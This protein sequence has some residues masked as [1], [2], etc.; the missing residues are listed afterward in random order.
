MAVHQRLGQS[1]RRLAFSGIEETDMDLIDGYIRMLR[2]FLPRAQRDDIARE[3]AEEI[4]AQALDKQ[5]ELGR[6]LSVDEQ[7][8]ILG[9]YGHPL[10]TAARYRSQQHLI[11]PIV[12]PYYWLA[13]KVVL[14]MVLAGHA[15]A[16]L[17]LF[18]GGPSWSEVGDALK[19][20]L[21]NVFAVIAWFTI[22]AALT[23]R[24][25]AK[26]QV[27][28]KWDPRTL[29]VPAELAGRA[30]L[31]ATRA[32]NR[33][34][35]PMWTR[36]ITALEGSPPSIFGLVVGVALSVWWLLA[37]RYPVLMFGP[38]AA[39]LDWGPDM[40]RLYPVLV[41]AQI[42]ALAEHFARVLRPNGRRFLW[43]TQSLWPITGA[44]FFYFVATARHQWVV[45]EGTTTA[46]PW[47]RMIEIAGRSLSLIDLV[48]LAFGIPFVLAAVFAG[49]SAAWRVYR[50]FSGRGGRGARSAP[51]A[52]VLLLSSALVPAAWAQTPNDAAIRQIIAE[53]IDSNRQ[54]VGI[55]AGIVTPQGR[56]VISHGR[57]GAADS[58]EVGPDTV[59][60]IGSVTKVFT[61]L[62]LAD[63]ARRGELGV[64]D[65]VVR[66]LPPAVAEATNGLKTMTLADLA[67][68]TAGFPFWPSGIPT[69]AEGTAAMAAY[70]VDQLYQFVTTFDAPAD[71]GTRWM[72]SNTDAGLLGLLLARR[73]E[74][75]YEALLASRIT[76]PLGMASTAVPV[77]PSMQSRL[78]MGHDAQLKPA[79]AWNVPAL[80]AGGSLHSTV[81]DLLTF[82]AAAGDTTTVLGAAMPTMLA[83]RK[84]APGFQQAL[85]WMVLGAGAGDGILVHDGNTRGYASSIVYDPASRTGV[86]VLSNSAASV[87]DI[88]RHLAR[89][90]I[91]LAKPLAPAPL[92][93]EVPIDPSLLDFYA[94]HYEPGP[95]ALFTVSREGDALMI[96]IPGIPK[97]RLRP[98]S[99]R[100]FFVAENTRVTVT[101]DVNE[102]GR[103]TRLLLKAPT[104]DVPAARRD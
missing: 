14:A 58:R 44:F 4:R 80:A 89:P 82:L 98:E 60:E 25:L 63:M 104:G 27:L 30:V 68:H 71:V 56:R 10:L 48:N 18:G 88:A 40:D 85:G 69:S 46:G 101:F 28:Q 84:Q 21:Q 43:I 91:P 94:G 22:I 11:G 72:Y 1:H 47:P 50:W 16:I 99:D 83:T 86:V 57:F 90:A 32:A 79:A 41:A 64:A 12:F 23:D 5:A 8:E 13:L 24:G 93:T 73:A 76:G 75:T 33:Q 55:V 38:G 51:S 103:V 6:P 52:C 31:H 26:S 67:T 15:I 54:S 96:Q 7:A 100:N 95:G 92:K 20:T 59:F 36:G 34:G 61:S 70:S 81:N 77:S 42:I 62:L 2:L 74:S 102:A 19:E 53:R 78:A 9:R 97:L 37:L 49:L 45:W 17:V 35:P 29:A 65:P 87:A 39:V 66:H 3:L